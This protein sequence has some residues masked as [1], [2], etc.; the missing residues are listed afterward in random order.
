MTA[1]PASPLGTTAATTTTAVVPSFTASSSRGGLRAAS[2][3]F[4]RYAVTL[5]VV[6]TAVFLLPRTLPGDPLAVL[7]GEGLA[8]SPE[9]RASLMAE[10]GLDR[11]L[12]EQY[13]RYLARLARGD[14]GTSV[15]LGP[16]GPLIADRLPWTVLLI[17]TSVVVAS[18]VSFRAG[19][20][21]AWHRG[22]RGHRTLLLAMT[23]LNAV[24]AYVF[25][26]VL[27]ILFVGVLPLF[28]SAGARTPFAV[29]ST[30]LATVGD[31]VVHL[32]LPLLSSGALYVALARLDVLPDPRSDTGRR[33]R[34]GIGLVTFAL[35]A[36]FGAVWELVERASDAVFGSALQEGND[37]TVG[38]LGMDCLGALAAALLLVL[39][40]VRGWGSVRRIAGSR[41]EGYD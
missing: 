38:D 32:V 27:L 31:V 25:A 23:G 33:H 15:S 34:L 21:S 1:E 8:P 9:V 13:G 20:A 12:I 26:P 24:P 4:G 3:A 22:E 39:W 6:A 29:Y 36:A 37:D 19:I 5:L 18:L 17:G 40:T 28:P 35:G 41:R 14:F 7:Q 30:P 16:V 11:P 2:A 10:H